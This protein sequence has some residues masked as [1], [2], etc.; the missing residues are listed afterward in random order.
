M[1]VSPYQETLEQQVVD[2]LAEEDSPLYLMEPG[3]TTISFFM[4]KIHEAYKFYSERLVAV[5]QSNPWLAASL[6][7]NA[8]TS[9]LQMKFRR[10]LASDDEALADLF[11]NSSYNTHPL[12]ELKND[13]KTISKSNTFEKNTNAAR[14]ANAIVPSGYTLISQ[15][16]PVSKFLLVPDSEGGGFALVASISHAVA[17]GYT[18]YSILGMLSPNAP[19][20]A[21]V[22][23]RR[24]GFTEHHMKLVGE[25]QNKF[26]M[27]MNMYNIG[28][29]FGAMC[30][31]CCQNKSVVSHYLDNE[32]VQRLKNEVVS[33]G[34][35]QYVSTTDLITSHFG[36]LEEFTLLQYAM[37]LRRRLPLVLTDL[38][39]G[40]YETALLLNKEIYSSSENVRKI[41]NNKVEYEAFAH[42]GSVGSDPLPKGCA[43]FNATSGIVTSW[44]FDSYSGDLSFGDCEMVLHTP[45]LE[46]AGMPLSICVI[47]KAT[48]T[49]LGVL[50]VVNPRSVSKLITNTDSP[51]SNENVLVN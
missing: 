23:T 20:N 5:L 37:N 16:S 11:G 30:C 33:K 51:L 7:R 10:N 18:Y 14:L 27:S 6:E 40:N 15:K 2:L 46:T 28:M 1:S 47:F 44:I 22:Q 24:P 35:V 42:A 8:S 50:Y 4:G 41:F 34:E 13:I 26:I 21:L 39:S 32:K 19:I 3:I 45:C 49:R 48:P 38:D 17:D 31:C 9:K 25:E 29:M 12:L 36:N 43:A